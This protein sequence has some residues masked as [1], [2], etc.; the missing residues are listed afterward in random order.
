[1]CL[2]GRI[3]IGALLAFAIWLFVG[4]PLLYAPVSETLQ[5]RPEAEETNR[6]ASNG[7]ANS[8]SLTRGA[9]ASEPIYVAVTCDEH[10]GSSDCNRGWW[11]RFWT[12]PVATFTGLLFIATFFQAIVTWQALVESRRANLAARDAEQNTQTALIITTLRFRKRFRTHSGRGS[13]P[14]VRMALRRHLG[15]QR[16][17]ANS[18]S[19]DVG[20]LGEIYCSGPGRLSLP[21]S[22]RKGRRKRHDHSS[23]GKCLDYRIHLGF[24]ARPFLDATTCVHLHLGLGRVQRYFPEYS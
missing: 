4:L 15:K 10:D 20:Q 14:T 19:P 5:S 21:R 1:M 6:H 7:S 18:K 2:E 11:L 17:N 22:W 3:T 9:R 23:Q 13:N 24:G 8:V 12:D 16:S